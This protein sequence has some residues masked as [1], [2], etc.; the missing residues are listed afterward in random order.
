[1]NRFA[2]RLQHISSGSKCVWQRPKGIKATGKE[3]LVFRQVQLWM[4]RPNGRKTPTDNSAYMKTN[5]LAMLSLTCIWDLDKNVLYEQWLQRGLR[6]NFLIKPKDDG[7]KVFQQTLQLQQHFGLVSTKPY[8]SISLCSCFRLEYFQHLFS[9]DLKTFDG[10][11]EDEFEE[12]TEHKHKRV[13]NEKWQKWQID[14]KPKNERKRKSCFSLQHQKG[15]NVK[16][17]FY[18]IL[19]DLNVSM[20]TVR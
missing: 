8:C 9:H 3:L 1:M 17:L 19:N 13:S 14:S 2:S 5:Y 18:I 10:L 4:S 16:S 15:R 7:S 11:T 12:C 6:L 20:A